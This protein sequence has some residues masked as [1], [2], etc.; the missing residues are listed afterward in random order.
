MRV[1]I[2]S[3][4]NVP[5]LPPTVHSIERAVDVIQSLLTQSQRTLVLTGAGVSVDSGI[6]SYRGE[7][8]M[9]CTSHADPSK[10]RL[11]PHL[12]P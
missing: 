11:P 7:N 3:L 10:R 1:N 9:Y 4:P 12:F 6:K 2:P 5:R 8:G